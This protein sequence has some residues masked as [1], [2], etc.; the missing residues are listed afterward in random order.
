MSYSYFVRNKKSTYNRQYIHTQGSRFK[1]QE[2]FLINNIGT[3]VILPPLLIGQMDSWMDI[4]HKKSTVLAPQNAGA[5]QNVGFNKIPN[6]Q[7]IRGHKMMTN[8][9]LTITQ[10]IP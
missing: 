2:I 3:R 5:P 4:G 6:S 1:I 10:N 9:K 8:P 7:C